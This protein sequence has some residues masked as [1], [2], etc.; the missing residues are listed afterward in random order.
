V[1]MEAVWTSET[2]ISCHNTPRR[3]NP[4]DLDLNLH[5]REN[6]ISQKPYVRESKAINKKS[7]PNFGSIFKYAWTIAENSSIA[8][9]FSL[10]V[11]IV[12]GD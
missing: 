4:E 10:K 1:K 5:R 3:H 7:K 11:N 6:L 9:S 2:M 8:A 12:E